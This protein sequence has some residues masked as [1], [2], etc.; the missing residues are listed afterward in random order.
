MGKEGEKISVV[1]RMEGGIEWFGGFLV[2]GLI[3]SEN[4]YI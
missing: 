2:K 3:G 4:G 1:G